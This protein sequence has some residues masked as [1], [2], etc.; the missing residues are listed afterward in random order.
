MKIK[1]V[2][3]YHV[4]APLKGPFYNALG[5]LHEREAI[6]IKVNDKDGMCGW[7][8]VVAFST[9]WYTEETVYTCMYALKE[10]LL[11]ILNQHTHISHP[12]EAAALFSSIR[13]HHMAKAGL[14]AA[15]WDLYSKQKGLSLAAIIGGTRE[16]IETGVV[17]AAK[18]VSKI[19]EQIDRFK[20]D[21]YKRYKIKINKENAISVLTA[22]RN[23]YPELPIMADANSSF[24]MEDLPLLKK[25]D[26][27]QLMMIEQPFSHEDL[28]DH[29]VLQKQLATPICLDESITSFQAARNAIALKS[30]RMISVKMGRLG[31]WRQALQLH[32]FAEENATELWCGGMIE[33]GISKAHNI[34]L[35]S[36][37]GFTIPG[38]ISAS[39]RYWEHELL[40]EPIEVKNGRIHISDRPGIG[41]TVNE[42]ILERM[43]KYMD[44]IT[45]S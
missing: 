31:G 13:G 35:A 41:Y 16:Y 24:T 29:S 7:G 43:A 26:D 18:D 39:G 45:C 20:E 42:Y 30:C 38:D 5:T 3:L 12:E 2:T 14:E 19:G 27:Y 1:S 17:I 15:I 21:G 10:F 6:I 36:L 33:F 44:V 32:Q 40:E 9:P 25:L 34:A 4:S 11:P 28:Y 22:I 8:E 37:P 23:Q